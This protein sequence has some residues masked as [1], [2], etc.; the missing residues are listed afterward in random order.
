MTCTPER[1]ARKDSDGFRS[2]GADT[3]AASVSSAGDAPPA[4]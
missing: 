1:S 4:G 2:T 3:A